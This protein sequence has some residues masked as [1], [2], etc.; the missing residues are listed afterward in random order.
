MLSL[1]Y[2]AAHRFVAGHPGSK[3]DGWDIVMFA[4]TTAGAMSVRGAFVDGQWGIETRVSPD[5]KGKWV[6]RVPAKS[7]R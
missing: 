4:P 2:A 3:W 5:E 1:D 6:F 7:I